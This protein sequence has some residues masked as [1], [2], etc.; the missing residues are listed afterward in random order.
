[1]RKTYVFFF[2]LAFAGLPQHVSLA[3]NEKSTSISLTEEKT[4][5]KRKITTFFPDGKASNLSYYRKGE[6]YRFIDFLPNGQL[7]QDLRFKNGEFHG[8][9]L[10]WNEMAMCLIKGK[11]K[12]GLP[13][14]GDFERWHENSKQYKIMT[15]KKGRLIRTTDLVAKGS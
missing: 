15:Y 5:S 7:F 13:Y 14:T 8:R 4:S 9:Y 10:I 12:N 3:Q 11:M 6:L 2:I 1:M